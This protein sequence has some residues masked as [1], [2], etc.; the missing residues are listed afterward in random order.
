MAQYTPGSGKPEDV[1]TQAQGLF[2]HSIMYLENSLGCF[3]FCPHTPGQG[4]EG[5]AGRRSSRAEKI[6][7]LIKGSGNE[8]LQGNVAQSSR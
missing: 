2:S 5:G 6:K 8:G 3:D 1:Q 7:N 4:K